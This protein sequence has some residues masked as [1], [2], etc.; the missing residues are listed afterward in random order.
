MGL[1]RFAGGAL[2]GIALAPVTGG[3]SLLAVGAASGAAAHVLGN[4]RDEDERNAARNEGRN[5]G[6][7]NGYRQ[8]SIDA[9]ARLA[10]IIENDDNLQIGAFALG[11]YVSNLDDDIDDEEIAVITEQLGAP[12][13]T[14]HKDYVRNQLNQCINNIG[15]YD[16]NWICENYLNKVDNSKMSILADFVKEIVLADDV[17]SPEEEHFLDYQWD[18]Y[19]RRRN[20]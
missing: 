1:F 10:D 8:G 11:L 4:M 18:P 13:S 3:T 15:G 5:E 2:L 14:F 7:E 20:V 17:V 16:F 6:F 19:L 12:D 9:G